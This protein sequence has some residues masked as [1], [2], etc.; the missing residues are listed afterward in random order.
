MQGNIREAQF[1]NQCCP[2]EAGFPCQTGQGWPR[3]PLW[4]ADLWDTPGSQRPLLWGWPD[5]ALRALLWTPARSHHPIH[6]AAEESQVGDASG[7]VWDLEAPKSER[8]T[9]VLWWWWDGDSGGGI[10]ECGSSHIMCPFSVVAQ[11]STHVEMQHPG[12]GGTRDRGF[13]WECEAFLIKLYKYVSLN[14]LGHVL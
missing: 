4:G 9:R 10:S 7:A 6:G 13:W 14:F 5:S 11:L 12:E 1:Q 8:K 2:Q 3:P